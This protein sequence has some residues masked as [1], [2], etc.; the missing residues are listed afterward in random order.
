MSNTQGMDASI[1]MS[2]VSIYIK[3]VGP[4]VVG[5]PPQLHNFG[6]GAA[7]KDA[8]D[9]LGSAKGQKVRLCIH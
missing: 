2:Y 7:I 5:V 9:W 1:N 3:D 8:N 6:A 4:D